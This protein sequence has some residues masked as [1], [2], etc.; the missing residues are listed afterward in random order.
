LAHCAAIRPAD[1]VEALDGIPPHKADCAHFAILALQNALK[2]C[3]VFTGAQR[4]S[5]TPPAESPPDRREAP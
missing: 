4:S 2:N 1:I 3:G 5:E